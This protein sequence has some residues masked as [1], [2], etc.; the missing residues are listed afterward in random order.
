MDD[1][2]NARFDCK[3]RQYKYFFEKTN[4]LDVDAM[5]AAARSFAHRARPISEIFVE[6]TR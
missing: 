1:A 5:R 3:W 2:L 6:W 4:A